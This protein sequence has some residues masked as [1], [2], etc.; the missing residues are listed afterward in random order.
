MGLLRF[1]E[2]VTMTYVVVMIALLVWI[3]IDQRR[4]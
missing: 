2:V 1:V 3:L 4:R